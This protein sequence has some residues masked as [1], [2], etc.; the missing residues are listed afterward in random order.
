MSGNR[1]IL[2]YQPVHA[3]LGLAAM[4]VF[5][6]TAAYLLFEAGIRYSG[7]RVEQLTQ[8][9]DSMEGSY[10]ALQK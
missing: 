1:K 3:W 9:L 2:V 10:E 6:A 4:L 8:Q 7:E 5:L